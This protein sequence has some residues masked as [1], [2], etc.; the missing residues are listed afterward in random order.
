MSEVV[1]AANYENCPESKSHYSYVTRRIISLFND[2]R[3]TNV[4]SVDVEPE[5]GYTT[6]LC[7]RDCSVR[8]TYGNDLG[9][10]PGAAEDLAKDK[11]HTKF[12]LEKLGISTPK[13]K[14][15][16]LPWWIERIGASQAAK[17]NTSLRGIDV[18]EAY[19]LGELSG[20]PAYIK[21]V[22]GS[23]GGGIYKVSDSDELFSVFN[24]YEHNRIS[25]ALIE[26]PIQNMPDYRVVV[27]DGKM[28][29]AYRRDP[30]AVTG[31]GELSVLE[32]I[33]LTQ[34][35]YIQ[36]GRDTNIVVNDAR[37]AAELKKQDI[38][39]G[40]VPAI[41][42]KVVLVP[43]SNLSMGG[44]SADVSADIHPDWI[45]L[46]AEIARNMN[47]RL[48]GIDLACTDITDSGAEYSVIEVNASPGLDHYA[49]SGE[50]QAKIVDDLYTRVLNTL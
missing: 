12:L 44:T 10:N 20:F 16:L 14:T 49:S 2:G 41:G 34:A 46:S 22:N 9:L 47:L 35:K 26:A 23:K 19:I 4:E 38:S 36:E 13:G 37:I 25:V 7:Y 29:S 33:E 17:G 18:A 6:R 48:C 15:F 11:G 8:I 30:L 5:Y 43:V 50:A 24:E 42:E 21:P 28:I 32:L 27:L 31:N 1:S 40:Y 39:Y 3:L 45:K